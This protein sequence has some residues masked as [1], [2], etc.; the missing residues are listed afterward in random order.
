MF[1]EWLNTEAFFLESFNRVFNL[2]VCVGVHCLSM[3]ASKENNIQES[4]S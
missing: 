2:S 4:S 1:L 3:D